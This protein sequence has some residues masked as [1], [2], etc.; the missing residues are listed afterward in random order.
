MHGRGRITSEP[1]KEPVLSKAFLSAVLHE[2]TVVAGVAAN[3]AATELAGAI[4]T[5]LKSFG[6]F[7]LPSFGTFRVA[8]TKARKGLNPRTGEPA[9]VKAG[10]TVRFKVS[11]VLKKSL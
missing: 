6:G 11:P 9:K 2:P 10:K 3:R 5:E 4:V 1:E 7:T 8:N